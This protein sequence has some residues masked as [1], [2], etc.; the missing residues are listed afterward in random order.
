M[1]SAGS[2]HGT[3]LKRDARNV[4]KDAVDDGVD[5][6]KQFN[7]VSNLIQVRLPGLG[8]EPG[9]EACACRAKRSR[10]TVTACGLLSLAPPPDVTTSR[11][12]FTIV[13][14]LGDELHRV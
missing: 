14:G 2:A 8:I 13:A 5:V 11:I 4:F 9:F 6:L 3:V 12:S 10:H 7:L 1:G